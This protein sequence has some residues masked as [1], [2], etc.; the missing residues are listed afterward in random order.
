MTRPNGGAH[1]TM[2]AFPV[3]IHSGGFFTAGNRDIV[4]FILVY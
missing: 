4:S 3:D 2:S 1:L